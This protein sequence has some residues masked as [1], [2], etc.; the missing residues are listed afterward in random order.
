MR[1]AFYAPTVAFDHDQPSGD[2]GMAR[3]LMR[4]LEAA[5]HEVEL[6]SILRSYGKEPVAAHLDLLLAK[7]VR[8]RQQIAAKWQAGRS[9]PDLWFTYH[10]YYKAPDLIGPGLARGA[11]IPYVTAEASFA[12]KRAGG[13]WAPFHEAS[14]DALGQAR[15]HFTFTE[16]DAEGLRT[17]GV[18]PE[19]MASLP[20]FIDTAPFAGIARGERRDGAIRLVTVAMMRGGRKLQSFF[21]L[22]ACLSRLDDLDWHLTLYGDGP[23]RVRVK[24]AFAALPPARLH[25]A[26]RITAQAMPQA[27]ARADI[28]IWPGLGE[29]YGLAY[30]EAAAAGLPAIAYDSGGVRASIQDGRTGL[31]AREGD[32]DGFA[33]ATRRLMK[34]AVLRRR[35]GA[36]GR[37]MV[38]TERTVEAAAKR[39]NAAFRA[40]GVFTQEIS[41]L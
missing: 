1:V 19:K 28:L 15:L 12:G 21:D 32:I 38:L 8:E 4:A 36:A 6:V 33:A 16:R 31:L 13:E 5:G 7:A 25:F 26:G 17:F 22:A 24:E 34:E 40:A 27:L 10:P 9:P 18:L 37:D 41:S 20:P 2:K 3:L 35:L 11:G 14:L 30:L 29:A 39:L 23:E